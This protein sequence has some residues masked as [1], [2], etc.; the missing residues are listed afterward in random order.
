MQSIVLRMHFL[1]N[2]GQNDTVE[3]ELVETGRLVLGDDMGSFDFLQSLFRIT[4]F[5]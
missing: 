2:F 4:D 5:K 1:R 3:A